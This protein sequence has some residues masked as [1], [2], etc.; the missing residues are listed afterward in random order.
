MCSLFSI[1]CYTI[2][3]PFNSKEGKKPHVLTPEKIK[4]VQYN[5]IRESTMPRDVPRSSALRND[6]DVK[7]SSYRCV[8]FPKARF[9]NGNF[10]FTSF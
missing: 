3:C 6:L 8:N 9:C 1:C 4:E 10:Q 2:P 5:G 7:P